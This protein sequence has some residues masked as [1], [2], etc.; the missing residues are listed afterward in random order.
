MTEDLTPTDT[1]RLALL[2][3]LADRMPDLDLDQ[4]EVEWMTL[5]DGHEALLVDGGGIDG[6][7]GMYFANVPNGDVHVVGSLEPLAPAVGCVV[8][9]P[10]GTRV[11]AHVEGDPLAEPES[12]DR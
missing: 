1:D 4:H 7:S 10:D 12:D 11:L 5:P 2:D 6:G 8:L 9:M 3:R